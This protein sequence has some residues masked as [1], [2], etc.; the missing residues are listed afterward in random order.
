VKQ[1]SLSSNRIDFYHSGRSWAVL[2]AVRLLVFVLDSQVLHSDVELLAQSE[3]QALALAAAGLVRKLVMGIGHGTQVAVLEA[4][5]A[6]YP[7]ARQGN[8]ETAAPWGDVERLVKK[9]LRFRPWKHLLRS[10][11]RY[12]PEEA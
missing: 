8:L 3:E 7:L 9:T 11:R 10:N 1:R 6:K 12:S 2:V 4:V 5:L